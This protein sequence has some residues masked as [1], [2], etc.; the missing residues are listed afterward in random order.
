MMQSSLRE[1][2]LLQV[3]FRS[4]SD[5][6][7]GC[8]DVGSILDVL[9]FTKCLEMLRL[10]DSLPANMRET[11]LLVARRIVELL[12]LRTLVVWD[13]P[14]SVRIFLAHVEFPTT[15]TTLEVEIQTLRVDDTI[16]MP[17]LPDL[18]ATPA[19]D[20]RFG[21]VLKLDNSA[22]SHWEVYANGSQTLRLMVFQ[23]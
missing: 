15:T 11:S 22:L 18:N 17:F 20:A 5:P 12:L 3:S 21:L 4:S 8:L 9:S 7:N 19:D 2:D 23:D 6:D 14:R 13:D 16:V 10:R 1:L